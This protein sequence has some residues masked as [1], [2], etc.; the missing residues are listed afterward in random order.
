MGL[1]ERAKKEGGRFLNPV[2]TTTGGFGLV[3]KVLPLYLRN[4]EGREP[5]VHRGRSGRTCE[6]TGGRRRA[7]CG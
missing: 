4:R 7:G 6:F 3:F 5:K 2:P 1:L